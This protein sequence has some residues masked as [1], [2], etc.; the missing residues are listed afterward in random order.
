MKKNFLKGINRKK[1]IEKVDLIELN[2]KKKIIKL[3]NIKRIY[4]KKWS[5]N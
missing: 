3:K 1:A 5:Y 2:K 4:S